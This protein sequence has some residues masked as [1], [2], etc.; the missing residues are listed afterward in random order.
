MNEAPYYCGACGRDLPR[1]LE[2]C[3]KCQGDL[4]LSRVD[5]P[6]SAAELDGAPRD[7]LALREPTGD[8]AMESSAPTRPEAQLV[9]V[10][11]S[12]AAQSGQSVA[13]R[14]KTGQPHFDRFFHGGARVGSVIMVD[15]E[16]GAGK[17]TLLMQLAACFAVQNDGF[18]VL[19][20]S[21]EQ[22]EDDLDELAERLEI[23]PDVRVWRVRAKRWE[24]IARVI[25]DIDPAILVL[26]SVQVF[27]HPDAGEQ[28]AG[29]VAQVKA[30]GQAAVDVTRDR[31]MV[32]FLVVQRNKDASF[33]GPK[34]LEHL[35][36]V[37]LSLI[38]A[39]GSDLRRLIQP[40]NRGG[41]TTESLLLTMTGLGLVPV[42]PDA[43]IAE[44]PN[45][46]GS[47]VL[48][49]CEGTQTLFVLV[50][51]L[52]APPPV[53]VDG[54]DDEASSKRWARL[55][56]APVRRASIG[57]PSVRLG[58]LT[59]VLQQ[60]AEVELG[61]HEVY[62]QVAGGLDVSDTAG[63]LAVIL[64]IVSNYNAHVVPPDVCVLG[65]VGLGG[66]IRGV[67]R[68]AQRLRD[69]QR[70]GFRRALVPASWKPQGNEVF[71][72]EIVPVG[73]I[74]ETI[75]WLEDQPMS[76]RPG[77][78]AVLRAEIREAERRKAEE[79]SAAID[80]SGASPGPSSSGNESTKKDGADS[81]ASTEP[82]KRRTR[83]KPPA[84]TPP[85]ST[86]P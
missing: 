51:A 79:Q 47:V 83:K 81:A 8:E 82:T 60:R 23:G 13:R 44:R 58:V 48:A 30:V 66:E 36:D 86:E 56:C 12:K 5:A 84:P 7:G 61:G 78:A 31:S 46:P 2:K 14:I 63:D 67:P 74:R 65:E 9:G 38:N 34:V 41:D 1:R 21:G 57:F 27:E 40:K 69:A 70:L 53:V 42:P 29:S 22:G 75:A 52:V 28:G 18:D 24:D 4:I 76:G 3:P 33:A 72:L 11:A 54:E 77:G 62:V 64:A 6:P 73:S 17:T 50:Q 15:G 85:S 20:V 16:P 49:A 10:A 59:A 55:A 43:F 80:L 39:P 37:R 68:T 19:Y 26:D 25:A 71:S 32:T 35:I 45:A